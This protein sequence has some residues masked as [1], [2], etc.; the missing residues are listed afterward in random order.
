MQNPC[1]TNGVSAS[2]KLLPNWIFSGCS[3]FFNNL[4][5]FVLT[6]RLHCWIHIFETEFTSPA[7]ENVVIVKIKSTKYAPLKTSILSLST[8]LDCPNL[9]LI[10]PRPICTHGMIHIVTGKMRPFVHEFNTFSY[11]W[12]FL[13]FW[14]VK[15]DSLNLNM[16][17]MWP[18]HRT[19]SYLIPPSTNSSPD[20]NKILRSTLKSKFRGFATLLK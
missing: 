10:I 6:V 5:P 7:A 18:D 20:V 3:D 2:A 17:Q 15:F 19:Y 12:R 8:S 16:L 13:Y 14:N 11:T 9:M 1:T 4:S